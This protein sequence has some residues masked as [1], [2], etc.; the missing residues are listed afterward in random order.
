VFEEINRS[1]KEPLRCDVAVVNI[2]DVLADRLPALCV[3]CGKHS[4][5]QIK[6]AVSFHSK[7]L[8]SKTLIG[9]LLRNYLAT[10]FPIETVV[11]CPVCREHR[12]H[13][14][15][16]VS[17]ASIGWLIP[18]L[19]GGTGLLLGFLAT[20]ATPQLSDVAIAGLV[21]GIIPGIA[22]YLIPVFCLICTTVKCEQKSHEEIT[23]NRVCSAFAR[24]ARNL[25]N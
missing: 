20:N 23:F 6:Q 21:V 19:S 3:I 14:N 16:P 2:K 15:R 13:W 7:P 11:A 24:A 1:N 5:H 22:A 10:L 18:I 4:T 8:E 17:F 12:N 9:T 25:R